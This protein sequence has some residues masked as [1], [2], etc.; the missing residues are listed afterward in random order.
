MKTVYFAYRI[1]K[2]A[3]MA[4]DTETGEPG[5]AYIKVK[6]DNCRDNIASVEYEKC[7]KDFSEKLGIDSQFITL[8]TMDQYNEEAG[9][10]SE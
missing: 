10:D 9:E 6:I 4:I 8:I 5:E 1:E 2:G 7:H 3:K